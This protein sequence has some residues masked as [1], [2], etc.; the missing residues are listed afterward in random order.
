M[1]ILLKSSELKHQQTQSITPCIM[2]GYTATNANG[3]DVNGSH[4]NG[5]TGKAR[6]SSSSKNVASGPLSEHDA[7]SDPSENSAMLELVIENLIAG[8]RSTLSY[9]ERP[10]KSCLQANLHD[11]DRL[12]DHRRSQ[13]AAEATDLLHRTQKLLDPGTLVLADHFLG[14][15]KFLQT[16]LRLVFR[17]RSFF[18]HRLVIY[19]N[20]TLVI[21]SNAPVRT[22]KSCSKAMSTVNA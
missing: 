12:P 10:L 6:H 4:T 1:Y 7:D 19:Q 13:L 3:I 22:A 15:I 8:L 18:T 17:F 21:Q 20:A 2:I 16:V 5:D 14:R 11:Y 9:F